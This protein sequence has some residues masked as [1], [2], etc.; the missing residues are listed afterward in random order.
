[1][2]SEDECSL[3]HQI[4]VEGAGYRPDSMTN[5]TTAERNE[6][7]LASQS[8]QQRRLWTHVKE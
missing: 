1:M 8:L 7:S 2:E 6:D 3:S 5:T 4:V